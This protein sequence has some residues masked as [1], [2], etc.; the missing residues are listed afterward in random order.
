[1]HL[2]RKTAHEFA[3]AE[4][5]TFDLS[6]LRVNTESAILSLGQEMIA[7]FESLNSLQTKEARAEFFAVPGATALDYAEK[8]I[9]LDPTRKVV[10]GIRHKGGNVGYPFVELKVNFKAGKEELLEIYHEYL[11]A[12]FLKF[13]PKHLK[14]W[15]SEPA[16]DFIGNTYVAGESEFYGVLDNGPNDFEFIVPTDD[17]YYEW[18]EKQYQEFHR[19]QPELSAKVPVND[20][21]TMQESVEQGLL[22]TVYL[23]GKKVGL[24][25]AENSDLLGVKGLY[26]NEIL[27]DQKFRGLGY[28]Q[29]IQRQFVKMFCPGPVLVWGT[30]DWQ[31]KSSLKTALN[32]GRK[33]IRVENFVEL[34]G[35]AWSWR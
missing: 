20:P 10:C 18:Y 34:K 23:D 27:I 2:L 31:N 3:C 25:A 12:H 14:F 5:D 33:I 13:S 19:E 35:E 1:V 29:F 7:D 26:F 4:L 22:A 21:S 30:I 17:S 32:N 8:F 11:S 6:G 24:I 16:G 28:G 9:E 15:S